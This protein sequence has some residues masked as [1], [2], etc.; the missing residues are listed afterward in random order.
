MM[1]R[2]PDSG[3]Q[4]IQEIHWGKDKSNRRRPDHP[5]VAAVFD[6]LACVAASAVSNPERC[7]VLDVGCGNGFLSWALEKHF[8]E[9]AGLDFSEEMLK[10]NPCRK[11]YLGTATDLPFQD[12]SF[13]VA[14]A[15]HLLH[16]LVPSDRVK[17]LR[18]MNR[19]ARTA[20]VSFEPNRNNP[21]M[22]LF[23]LIMREERMALK[24]SRAYMRELHAS[25]DLAPRSIH[26]QNWVPPNKA[27]T[28]WIPI[29]RWID[30]TPLRRLGFDICCVTTL[31]RRGNTT[32]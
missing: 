18:E 6:A 5:A 10:V 23:S 17:T 27:P 13:D 15:C 26:V 30:R 3:R 14:V 25:A 1:D 11:K 9:V 12:N 31:N 28:W 4:K 19:V 32:G 2:P 29:G 24:F 8:K 16:H 22:F 7:S 20:V 21:A